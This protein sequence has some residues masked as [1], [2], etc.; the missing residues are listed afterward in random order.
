MCNVLQ[1]KLSSS[2][3]RFSTKESQNIL[4]SYNQIAKELFVLEVTEN[5]QLKLVPIRIKQEAEQIEGW[6]T[7]ESNKLLYIT[8]SGRVK[9]IMYKQTAQG[10]S[11]QPNRIVDYLCLYCGQLQSKSSQYNTHVYLCHRGPAFCPYCNQEYRDTKIM[12]EHKKTCKYKCKEDNC[13]WRGSKILKEYQ[14]HLKKH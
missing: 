3:P 6:T 7:L 11:T 9:Y 10:L 2:V 4:G 12:K 13:S 8:S 14:R 1:A 5:E